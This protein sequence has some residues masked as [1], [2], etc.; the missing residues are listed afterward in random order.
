MPTRA[1]N[2]PGPARGTPAPPQPE[3][4][5][6][7]L[8]RMA[9]LPA[10]LIRLLNLAGH[11]GPADALTQAH[12]DAARSRLLEPF[13][14]QL[15]DPHDDPAATWT[16]LLGGYVLGPLL[17]DVPAA[18]ASAFRRHS[19]SVALLAYELAGRDGLVEPTAALAAALLHDVG[20]LALFRLLPKAYLA[21]YPFD[22]DCRKT[23]IEERRLL[24]IDHALLGRRLGRHWSLP[25][26][27]RDAIWLH[28]QNAD[29]V[30]EGLEHAGVI[31]LVQQ[32]HRLLDVAAGR[33]ES[34]AEATDLAGE[35][36]S[37]L[38][39]AL[40][41]RVAGMEA[42]TWPATLPEFPP[43][44]PQPTA[45]GT[46]ADAASP[47]LEQSSAWEAVHDLVRWVT[48][49]SSL[50]QVC[51]ELA[52]SFTGL[53]WAAQSDPSRP[54]GMAHVF[55]IA[56]RRALLASAGPS[57][58]GVFHSS[59]CHP[60]PG[61]PGEPLMPAGII[62]R[63]LLIRGDDWSD[64]IDLENACCLPLATEGRMIGGILLPTDVCPALS[65]E[66]LEPL[67]DYATFVLA[68]AVERDE[69]DNL[70]EQLADVSQRLAQTRKALAEAQAL[71]SVVEMAAGAAH[72]INNPLAVI[73]GRA[74]LLAMRLGDDKDRQ[75]AELIA[76]KAQDIS[77]IATDLMAFA[78]PDP[79][80]PQVVLAGDLVENLKSK[81]SSEAL[82][83]S[84]LPP[85]DIAGEANC[86][87][88]WTD[89][90][91]IGDVLLE[92]VRNAATAS[93]GRCRIEIRMHGQDNR[94][95]L[96]G[97]RDDGPGMDQATLAAAFA[98]FFSQRP[99][100]RGRGMGLARARR[101]V[102]ANR[103]RIWIESRSGKGTTVYLELPQARDEATRHEPSGDECGSSEHP[104]H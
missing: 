88:M 30:P 7:Q 64:G 68:W 44:T 17:A 53:L 15:P 61:L 65:L 2:S 16:A 1:N 89:P 3:I 51:R 41:A 21:M 22:G 79:P 48:P 35:E 91:Q 70:V 26:Y 45:A 54:A 93:Q 43:R 14:A 34:T 62:I 83:K 24:G 55:A 23:L 38:L 102:L 56:G 10:E 66:A 12:A 58:S 40:P 95:V 98:P 81:I 11:A 73:S 82:R 78:Q 100:G 77:D 37:A 4:L 63:G 60:S 49:E 32:A 90:T 27:V 74:Q 96:I 18:A 31:R 33:E 101:T 50:S 85:V 103:G 87:A 8:P 20:Q 29:A 92:L 72:E 80:Q 71:A 57:G 94:T 97:L 46:P 9:A 25:A 47:A 76:Q 84:P 28:H 42:L 19:L 69:A 99:A 75:A 5:L 59:D 86:P 52:K 6:R 104:H 39:A 67:L 36:L 13:R